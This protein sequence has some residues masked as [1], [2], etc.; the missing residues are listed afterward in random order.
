LKSN[1]PDIDLTLGFTIYIPVAGNHEEI[2][3]ILVNRKKMNKKLVAEVAGVQITISN[4]HKDAESDFFALARSFHGLLDCDEVTYK[5]L[6]ILENIP[7]HQPAHESVK[8]V[9][10]AN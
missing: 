1:I 9:H 10:R 7:T 2:D 8:E 4:K 6:W 5:F 3:A